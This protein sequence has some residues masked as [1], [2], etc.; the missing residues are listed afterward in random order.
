MSNIVFSG[1]LPAQVFRLRRKT[2]YKAKTNR[3]W[4]PALRRCK[5]P[6]YEFSDTKSIFVI[7]LYLIRS[8]SRLARRESRP[9]QNRSGL[10]DLFSLKGEWLARAVPSCPLRVRGETGL[11]PLV[12]PNSFFVCF[13]VTRFSK[14]EFALGRRR[15]AGA[16]GLFIRFG[17]YKKLPRHFLFFFYSLFGVNH[18]SRAVIGDLCE[19]Q[20]AECRV[21]RK[22][23]LASASC[24]A[25]RQRGKQA[26]FP[27]KSGRL[28]F[29]DPAFVAVRFLRS[30][31][32]SR[33]RRE[34]E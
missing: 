7:F 3:V 10:R 16:S 14:K 23:V 15:C 33:L 21:S 19:T 28:V 29:A 32:F 8:D 5:W 22:R 2:T 13:P 11:S 34:K 18:G 30:V 9:L 17:N 1:Q 31:S 6:L 25:S 12:R 4:P 20:T 27:Y 26:V 24:S